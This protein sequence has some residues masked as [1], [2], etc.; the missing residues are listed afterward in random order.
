MIQNVDTEYDIED[1]TNVK[2][3]QFDKNADNQ[4]KKNM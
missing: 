1:D 3:V 2:S 4:L